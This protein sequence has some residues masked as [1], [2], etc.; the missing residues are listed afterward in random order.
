MAREPAI[1]REIR[2]CEVCRDAL[3][4]YAGGAQIGQATSSVWSPTLKKYIALATVDARYA[5]HGTPIQ[6]EHT[7]EYARERVDAQVVPRP[8]FDPPRKK[9]RSS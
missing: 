1:V 7:V 5:P 6:I 3:P 9:A 8:F 4:L 2:A